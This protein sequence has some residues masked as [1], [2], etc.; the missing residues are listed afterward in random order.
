MA[1]ARKRR[2]LLPLIYQHLLQAGYVRA[3]REVK[4]QSGQKNF[5]AQ[6]V[7]LLDIYTHWQQTSE[8]GRKRK[9]EDD[10][11]LEAKKT[12][13]SDP[14]S[15]SESS[16]EEE[17]EEAEAIAA[18]A[19]PRLASTSSSGVGP[20]I[21]SSV[22]EKAKTGNASKTVNSMPHPDSGKAV[23]HLLSGKSAK[24]SAEPSANTILVSETEEQ[25]SIRALG[26]TAKL[27]TVSASQ[28]DSSSEDTSSSSNETDVEVK[29]PVK[30][31]HVKSSPA[32]PK[33]SLVSR[34]VSTP[35]KVGDMA[36]QVRGG[37]CTSAGRTMNLK[38]ESRVKPLGKTPQIR[39]TSAP[40]PPGKTG[41]AAIQAQR[42]KQEDS[43]SSSE[44][45]DSEE[46]TS[47]IKALTT[48][49]VQV[50]PLGKTPQVRAT[51]A[52]AK[53]SPR[54]GPP[55]APSRRTGPA[56]T[57]AQGGKQEDSDSSSEESDSD[58]ETPAAVKPLG[59]T[60][61]VR[62]T[63]APAKE[64]PRKGPPLAPSRKTGLAATQA[65]GGKQEDS[66][67]SSE[68]SDSDGE[69]PAAV[70]L[71]AHSN[72]VK[73]LGKTPQ[74]RSSSAPAKES[75]RNGALL[76]PTGKT[77]PVATPAQG[78]KPEESDSS[79]EESD[80]DGETPAATAVTM[81]PALAK[82][83]GNPPLTRSASGP[84]KMPLRKGASPKPSQ[85]VGLVATQVK[86]ERSK[87]DSESSEESFDSEEEEAPAVMTPA[88]GKPSL[89]TP[90]MK[91]SPRKGTPF[92]P[93]P[94]KGA[95][96]RTGTPAPWKVAAAASP[97][98]AQGTQRPKE[99]ASSS[100][101]A[102]GAQEAAPAAAVVQA[103]SLGR[104]LQGRAASAPTKGPSGKGAT[105]V[106]PRKSE[107]TLAQVR[108]EAHQ[109][110]ESSEEESDDSEVSAITPTQGKLPTRT[111]QS[112]AVPAQ[113][114]MSVP[115]G[116]KAVTAAAQAQKGCTKADSRAEEDSESSEQSSVSE[117]ETPAQVKL[118]GKTP[119]VRA[120]ST[121]AKGS[122]QKG[123][124]PAASEKTGPAATQTQVGE[125]EDSDSSS[126][127][128]DSEEE[129]SAI[130]AL[131]TNPVQVK[132]LGKTPQVRATSAP[133][134]EFPRKGPPPAPSRRTGPAANQA[135]E[136]KQE[137]SGSSSEESDS[138]EETPAIKPLT[139][140]PVQVKP[141]GKTPQ[142]RATSAPAKESPRKGPPPA[143]SRR[144]GPAGTQA[145]GGKQEDSDSS[146][147]ESDSDG[148]TPAAVA[149]TAHSN[150]VKPLGKTPQVRA[151]TAPAKESPRKGP[152]LA[153][154]RKTGLAATQAQGGKQEDSDSSSEESGSE[155]ETPA[156]MTLTAHSNQ[157]NPLEKTLQVKAAFALVKESPRKGASLALPGK[158]GPATSQAQVQKQ[159]D[160]DSSSE[161]SDS[162]EETPAVATLITS[163]NQVKSLGKTPQV[164][165]ASAPAK[166]FP[167]KGAPL[168]PTGNTGAMASQDQGVKQ[169]DSDSSSEELDSERETPA[170]VTSA[171]LAPVPHH[172]LTEVL[173][174]QKESTSKTARS[175]ALTPAALE[176]DSEG[177]SESSDEEL[178]SSQVIKPPLIFVDPNRSPAG[179]AATPAQ[180]HPANAPRKAQASNST[181][182][183]SSSENED[184]DVIPSTQSTT[185][186][187][188]R[189]VLTVPIACP[190]TVPRAGSSEESGRVSEGKKQEVAVVQVGST[191]GTLPVI[192]PQSTPVQARVTNKVRTPELPKGQQ[193]TA[194][195]GCPKAKAS[196][197]SGDSEDNCDNSSGSEED[198]TGPRV[199]KST[200]RLAGPTPSGKETLVEET[201]AESSE[202]EVVAPSQSLLSGY[203]TP[204]LPLANSQTPKATPRPDCKPSV[205]STPST[206]DDPDG[207]QETK[208]QHT[209]GT[210]SPKT[211][212]KEA[213]SVATPQKP[214]KPKKKAMSTTA[215]TQAL[216]NSITQHLM[217]QP[218]PLNEA[219]VQASVAKVLAELL[220]QERKKAMDTTK[221]NSKKGRKRKLSGDQSAANAPKNKKKQQLVAGEGREG[222]DSSEKTSQTSKGKPK[223]DKASG[224]VKKKK[225]SPGSKGTKDK[226]E[227]E[228]GTVK[229]EGSNQNDPKS[230]KEKKKS[231][232][233]K[234]D[235]DKKEKKKAK[236]AS[237]RDLDSPS[238]KKK[239]KQTADSLK[240]PA[241]AKPVSLWGD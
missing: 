173:S 177:S 149:L 51:S 210:M 29:P 121:P 91:V 234:K 117:E 128:S 232:K 136:G 211:G 160:S 101:E 31:A 193:A 168:V 164:K 74:V 130:K 53:E 179:P 115:S 76:V 7:T 144:T 229:V 237:V 194:S 81:S 62:A 30:A 137:D 134:K 111:P 109:G 163:S 102:S 161:E 28:V 25:G 78:G 85:R 148:E 174:P 185:P 190:M 123:A 113:D 126:E 140:N 204:G 143:P 16:E 226:P 37:A 218:W 55:P 69:T 222:A 68:E 138:E 13:V 141:L 3:A 167:R 64:S 153:P 202:D 166:E 235:K 151:T 175:K 103:K 178:P 181:A 27:G 135:Q 197:S 95:P 207:K 184:E 4:E 17:E 57:Q 188:R 230:K 228:L 133:A 116:R 97:A 19:A 87:E 71:T 132:P 42:G 112:S 198:T 114:Q 46:E 77:G 96:A 108:T 241:L 110:S 93:T 162:E 189:S 223:R 221:E 212:R 22:K 191:A 43:G 26:T 147:E 200:P 92:T 240:V 9:A 104:G 54:K 129:T 217:S 39:A 107:P 56:G 38:E 172:V 44:E 215:S 158:S 187:I 90:Q 186:A 224:D 124:P 209:A 6:P 47:A 182:R 131:T 100:K 122:S 208:A 35:G 63:T 239:K 24:K 233:R 41:P 94:T 195:M 99:D 52:P 206:K 86:A 67:S 50:K 152:P 65:Q 88:Q 120:A 119:L 36:P 183:S 23:A 159:A 105:P 18:K 146:S 171:Q 79:S 176:K 58:G 219:Q 48:N 227:G 225:G 220:E 213:T 156:A 89:K 12:R 2:E 14:V 216:Q 155:E 165:D 5:L 72:Q 118:S 59:K 201:T 11:A 61:Q 236:K 170:C 45:S 10:A 214:Q 34:G 66:D 21:P 75:L 80:S 169:E 82:P 32:P 40:A 192:C 180:T 154:S 60:P 199:A 70:A 231:N 20:D 49:P 84:T 238:Q 150:Q 127:E 8:L 15:T 157:V 205:S 139:T 125:Q 33:E 73:P 83:L 203:V 142:V 106:P 145:Q 1:E 98:V 196:R